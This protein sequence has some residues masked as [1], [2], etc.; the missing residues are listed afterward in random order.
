MWLQAWLIQLKMYIVVL[1]EYKKNVTT[2]NVTTC[3]ISGNSEIKV[4]N[5]FCK[6]MICHDTG[7][8]YNTEASA[9]N[10]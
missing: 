8:H 10:T 2:H 4:Y 3:L 1:L 5:L 9:N 7:K 6:H